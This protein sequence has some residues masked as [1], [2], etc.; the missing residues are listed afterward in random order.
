MDI[1]KK[2]S[3]MFIDRDKC[4]GLY[5]LKYP[6]PVSVMRAIRPVLAENQNHD[7]KIM[8]KNHME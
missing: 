6:D 7:L 2:F 8:F 4:S 5:G 1:S 3:V